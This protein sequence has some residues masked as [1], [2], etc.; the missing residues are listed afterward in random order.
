[1]SQDRVNPK[2][3]F[4]SLLEAIPSLTFEGKRQLH[5]LLDEELFQAEADLLD[6]DPTVQ[7]EV[8]TALQ[9]Y[10]AGDYIPLEEYVERQSEALS[11]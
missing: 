10:K 5:A 11:E 7:A 4:A 2:I 1:M 6:Q 3:P 9:E 8:E